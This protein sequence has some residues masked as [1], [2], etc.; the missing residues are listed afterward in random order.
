MSQP[1]R[2]FCGLEEKEKQL[3]VELVHEPGIPTT[4]A[5]FGLENPAG[6]EP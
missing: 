1:F 2:K 6:A 4:G 5:I 3:G